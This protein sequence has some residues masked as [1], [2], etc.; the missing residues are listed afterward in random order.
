MDIIRLDTTSRRDVRRFLDFPFQLYRNVPQWV[1]P[2]ASDASRMLDRRKHPFY[3][4]SDADFFLALKA[5]R[6]VGR[7]AILENKRYNDFNQTRTA[8]FY[9]F[10]AENDPTIARGLF[11]AAID[12]ARA[13]GL[14]EING[15]KG[16]TALDGMGLLVKGFEHRPALGIAYNLDYYA[17]LLEDLDFEGTGDIVSGY[18]DAHNLHFP[19]KIHQVAELVQKRR[20]LRI[21]RFKTRRD[22]QQIIEPLKKMYND[23]LGGTVG[24]VPLTNDEVNTIAQQ[25]LLFADPKLIKIVMKDDELAGFLFAYP[26]VSAAVQR[27]KGK[28][29]PFGWLD[30]WLELKRTKWININGAGIVEKYRGGGGTALLFSE[31]EKSVVEGG[32]AHADLVQ[33][34]ADN[35]K[36][37]REVAAL[38]I[39][40]Y[41]THRM[42]RKIIA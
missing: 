2:F 26:D 22:L 17:G 1:P 14:T 20:G 9:L 8:L 38:G 41:K 21:V 33:I 12:W 5:D 11:D 23:S 34:G 24:N 28:L 19:E 25:L 37:Q 27:T 40:F 32:F 42:Y 18:L 6:V 13:R 10:E 36:M 4:H 29:F 7:L 35:D 16:F 15:P 3:Q 39:D 30:L 31:M